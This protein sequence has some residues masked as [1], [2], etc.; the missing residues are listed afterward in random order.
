MADALAD[1]VSIKP[2]LH[3]SMADALAD[4]MSIKPHLQV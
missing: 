2:H 1:A 4:A 3:A